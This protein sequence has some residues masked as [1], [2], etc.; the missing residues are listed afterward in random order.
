M[1]TI[2]AADEKKIRSFSEKVR[3]HLREPKH[4]KNEVE[5]ELFSNIRS[6]ADSYQTEKV[7][8]EEA[9]C[10][11]LHEYGSPES[12]VRELSAEYKVRKLTSKKLLGLSGL[13]FLIG[14]IVV[15]IFYFWNY[16]LVEEAS[17]K[18]SRD[19]ERSALL[20]IDNAE[21]ITPLIMAENRPIEAVWSR[22]VDAQ[23]GI[24]N[25]YIF[26]EHVS[27]DIDE[28]ERKNSLFHYTSFHGYSGEP[29]PEYARIDITIALTYLKNTVVH[30]G[31][32]LLALSLLFFVYWIIKN[33]RYRANISRKS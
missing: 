32:F 26:P 31:V 15:S 3:N 21:I 4:V 16:Y 13:L 27:P 8:S 2:S 28:Y 10:L 20:K 14:A 1:K 19:L 12:V 29:G 23:E 18:F 9:V 24:D 33:G 22:Y 7:N 6:L 17:S 11:A 30:S 25:T 5:E